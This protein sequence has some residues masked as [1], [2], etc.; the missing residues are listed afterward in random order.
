MLQ[1]AAKT[2]ANG[3]FVPDFDQNFPEAKIK[4]SI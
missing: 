3:A 1:N 2:A 4:V